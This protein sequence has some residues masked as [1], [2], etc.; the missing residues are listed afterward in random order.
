MKSLACSMAGW[1]LLGLI[2]LSARAEVNVLTYHN[3]HAR[4]GQNTNETILRPANVNTNTFGKLF[5]CSVDGY[6]YAQPLYVSGLNIPGRGVHNVIFIATEHNT[7]YAFDADIGAGPAGGLLWQTNLGP[8]AATPNSDFGNRYGPYGD[9]NPEVG[10]TGTPVIDLPS[11][12][13]YVDAFTH[14]GS[15]YYHRLHA[16]NI[17]NG[18][19]QPFSPVLVTASV[20]GTGVG[21][22]GSVVT[23]NS[24]QQIQRCALTLAGGIVYV[25]YAGYADTNP[26]HGWTIGFSRTNLQQLTNYVFNTTP[27]STVASYGANAGEGGIW[28]AGGGLAVDAD[29][30]LYFEVGNGVFTA[31]NNS[32]GTEYGDSFIKLSTAGSLSVTDYF[33]PY[34]Q[35]HLADI[36]LDLGSGGVVLLPDQPGPVP[37]LLVGAGKEGKIY[38]INRDMFT[39]GNNHYNAGGSTDAVLQTVAGQSGGS[40]DTPA[41]FNGRIFYAGSG[42]RLKAFSLSGGALSTTPVSTGPRTYAFPGAT[43]A[44]SANGTNNGIVWTLQNANPAVLAASDPANL[45]AEIY[46]SAQAAANRDRLTNAVKFA[47]PTIAN[48]KVCVGNQYSVSV[49]GLLDPYLNWKYAHFDADATNPAVA[50][51]FADPDNDGAVNLLECALAS[52][53]NAPNAG[54]SLTG[55][56]A[57]NEFQVQFNR[58]LL[59]TNFTYVVQ[60]SDLAGGPWSDLTTYTPGTGWAP[61]VAGVTAVESQPLLA[62]PDRFVTVTI[63]DPTIVPNT[64]CRAFRVRVHD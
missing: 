23:F 39:A 3:D 47:V 48:G 9:I 53:P 62:A 42:N 33:T 59:T 35:Q 37:H 50:G 40:Y 43:P 8:S 28:M 58:N 51:D 29:T 7:V 38:L 11:N 16:L 10:I 2:S 55:A 21:G 61:N 56:R 14:E 12:T 41:Y 30:N 22:N 4:T 31:T 26:Y 25:S 5:S 20:A 19:E 1:C 57:G 49:F 64:T 15:A 32:G 27:N 17:T 45:A 34:N 46:S 54:G 52:D 18:T 44:V 6:V 24:I 36:D 63:T 13:L 60:V